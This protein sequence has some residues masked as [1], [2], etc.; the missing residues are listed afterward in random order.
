[1]LVFFTPTWDG[2]EAAQVTFKPPR[3]PAPRQSTGGASRDGNNCLMAENVGD[4]ASITALLPSSRIGLTV[5]ERPTI[6]VY[7]PPTTAKTALFS[8]HDEQAKNHYQKTINLPAKPGVM[9][10]KLPNSAPGIKP[11]KN[12]QW[13]LAM[14]CSSELEPDSPL[15]SGWIQRVQYPGGLKNQSNSSPSLELASHLAKQGI[16]YD[17]IFE[18][19]KLRQAEPHNQTIQSS[20]QQLL[21]AVGLNAIA[22]APLAPRSTYLTYGDE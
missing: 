20:W 19:A 18:L 22:N 14:I 3:L 11:G 2:L 8:V 10:I 16:W 12:Y 4:T 13:S 5:K 15:V 1:M 9:A 6:L 7:I 17:T 21:N